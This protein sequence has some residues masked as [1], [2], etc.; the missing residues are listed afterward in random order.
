M[1]FDSASSLLNKSESWEDTKAP[2][3]PP[4]VEVLVKSPQARIVS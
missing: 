2:D 4:P 1:Q 3:Q